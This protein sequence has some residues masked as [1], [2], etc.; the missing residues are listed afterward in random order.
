MRG[1]ETYAVKLRTNDCG[2]LQ[3]RVLST[4]ATSRHGEIGMAVYS[5]ADGAATATHS[6]TGRCGSA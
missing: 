4:Q 6:G 1:V 5:V 3:V 2:S